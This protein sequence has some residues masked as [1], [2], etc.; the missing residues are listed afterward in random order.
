MVGDS[1]TDMEFGKRLGMKTV[2]IG[3][4]DGNCDKLIDIVEDTLFQFYLGIKLG[5]YTNI[6]K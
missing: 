3:K 4:K 2:F 1:M 5:R 6:F